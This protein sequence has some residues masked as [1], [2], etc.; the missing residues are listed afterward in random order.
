MVALAITAL[1]CVNFAAPPAPSTPADP[2]QEVVDDP[3]SIPIAAAHP[4]RDGSFPQDSRGETIPLAAALVCQDAFVSGPYFNSP[5]SGPGGTDESI[6]QN[7]TLGMSTTGFNCNSAGLSWIADDFTVSETGLDVDRL[8]F[9]AYQ[10][11]STT[12]S[13]FTGV[14]YQIWDGPP[15]VPGSAVIFGDLATNRMASTEWANAYRRAET[16]PGATTRPIMVQTCNGG[17]HLPPGTYWLQYGMTGILSSGPWQPPVALWGTDVT[18][19]AMSYYMGFWTPLLDGS[20]SAPAQGAPFDLV[21]CCPTITV[22]PPGP[23]VPGPTGAPYPPVAFTASTS[24]PDHIYDIF[25]WS[26][27]AGSLPDGLA[28]DPSS[29]VLAGTPTLDGIYHFTIRAT[30]ASAVECFGENSYSVAIGCPEISV[31]GFPAQASGV[32]GSPI[33]PV[34]FTASG[35]A[36]PYTFT[37][38]GGVVPAGLKLTPD[39]SLTGVPEE[40]GTFTFTVEAVDMYGCRG[41]LQFTVVI[42]AYDLNFFDDMGR[43]RIC[44][45]SYTGEFT[46][47]I[48]AGNGTGSYG[49]KGTVRVANGQLTLVTPSG[50]PYSLN[51]RYLQRYHKATAY[52]TSRPNRVN[53]SLMDNNTLDDPPG[54]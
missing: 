41:S 49:G 38:T 5:G 14:R 40:W 54:C 53:S 19:N 44:A 4:S 7:S 45:N 11:G 42:A 13:T 2:A 37:V 15:N 31:K 52:F 12:A 33:A 43:S 17:F 16:T 30:V 20:A 47:T 48:L 24:N 28:L 1:N 22:D 26:V 46:Y 21:W 6:L 27:S 35:G 8:L 10:T 50:L 39:G 23:L 34:L 36:D 9:Y 51:L 25:D 29:G 32:V 3:E 18:G